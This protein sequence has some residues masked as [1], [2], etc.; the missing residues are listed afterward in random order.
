MC[1]PLPFIGGTP[2]GEGLGERA[3]APRVVCLARRK[4]VARMESGVR[5]KNAPGFHPGYASRFYA[6]YSPLPFMGEGLGER[7]VAPRVVCLARRKP[8]ARMQSGVRLRNAPGFHPGYAPKLSATSAPPS[9]SPRRVRV[10]EHRCARPVGSCCWR[11]AWQ[12]PTA[13]WPG[14][15]RRPGRRTLREPGAGRWCCR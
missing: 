5:L 13:R 4:P 9:A 10:A 6:M 8:V 1:S 11:G 14:C 15:N 2:S 3:L 7:A 12:S